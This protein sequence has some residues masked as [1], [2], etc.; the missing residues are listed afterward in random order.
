M[1]L[2]GYNRTRIMFG[3]TALN[4]QQQNN[5]SLN[6]VLKDFMRICQVNLTAPM[7]LS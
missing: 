1:R 3:M 4:N 5:E 7:V 6:T 2:V